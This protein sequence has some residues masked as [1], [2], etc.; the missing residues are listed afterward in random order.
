[1]PC[2][3][4]NNLMLPVSLD[5][6]IDDLYIYIVIYTQ[7]VCY[8]D[9]CIINIEDGNMGPKF[10]KV[11]KQNRWNK[12]MGSILEEQDLV[13]AT[14]KLKFMVTTHL[15]GI[16]LRLKWNDISGGKQR[17]KEGCTNAN[18]EHVWQN[19]FSEKSIYYVF[20]FL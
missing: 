12:N 8:I 6:I 11:I 20:F 4:I 1:M 3:R 14:K 18:Y 10:M 16:K 5:L 13:I 17:V 19:L 9:P 15:S 7:C 2:F